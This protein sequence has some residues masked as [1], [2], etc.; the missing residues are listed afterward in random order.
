MT[1]FNGCARLVRLTIQIV[2]PR[3]ACLLRVRANKLQILHIQVH[4]EGKFTSCCWSHQQ[5]AAITHLRLQTAK[6]KP[7]VTKF[8]MRDTCNVCKKDCSSI[9]QQQAMLLGDL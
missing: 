6:Q 3:Q 4:V 7:S 2:S 8:S 5:H 9:G 1:A